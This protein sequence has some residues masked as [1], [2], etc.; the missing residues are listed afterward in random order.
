MCA[1]VCALMSFFFCIPYESHTIFPCVYNLHLA[2][3]YE[4][5]CTNLIKQR[6]RVNKGERALIWCM[7]LSFSFSFFVC[8]CVCACVCSFHTPIRITKSMKNKIK[9]IV[10]KPNVA[11]FV[12]LTY[13]SLFRVVFI[14][15]ITLAK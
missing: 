10:Q 1:R 8:V 11:R 5:V 2:I 15:T 3:R 9:E 14:G 12:F 13:S 6:E 4:F 7:C